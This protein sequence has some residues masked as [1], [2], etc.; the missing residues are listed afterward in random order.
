MPKEIT[1]L[2]KLH[3]TET[4][5]ALPTVLSPVDEAMI[6]ATEQFSPVG[7]F[8][9]GDLLDYVIPPFCWVGSF[10]IIWFLTRVILSKS[11][12]EWSLSFHK[13]RVIRKST[14]C[15][16]KIDGCV[17]VVRNEVGNHA[18]KDSEQGE[19]WTQRLSKCST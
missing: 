16:A 12:F 7:T 14:T 2:D 1:E 5:N 17:A 9:C 19:H 10:S 3:Q 13:S 11:A 4:P 6:V 15:E 8:F 18:A